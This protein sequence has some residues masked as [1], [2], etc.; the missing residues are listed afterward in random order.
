MSSLTEIPWRE[1]SQT[2]P[3][4]TPQ[5]TTKLTKNVL[6]HTWTDTKDGL[7]YRKCNKFSETEE[8]YISLIFKQAIQKNDSFWLNLIRDKLKSTEVGNKL[9][10]ARKL[11][12]TKLSTPGINTSSC[13]NYRIRTKPCCCYLSE[14]NNFSRGEISLAGALLYGMHLLQKNM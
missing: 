2:R 10:L 3:K 11:S 7:E 1:E 4:S 13:R 5:R 8:I 14:A 6:R 12:R 9:L